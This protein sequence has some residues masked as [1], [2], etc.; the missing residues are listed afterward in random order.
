MCT[1]IDV[2]VCMELMVVTEGEGYVTVWGL[3]I[4]TNK[5][6]GCI[7][8]SRNPSRIEY[9]AFQPSLYTITSKLHSHLF[10]HL[11]HSTTQIMFT[12]TITTVAL[13]S[14]LVA[15]LPNPQAGQPVCTSST[16]YQ[17]IAE[18]EPYDLDFAI[19][20]GYRCT[21]NLADGCT[22]SSSASHTV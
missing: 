13:L 22:I 11:H 19:V 10:A 6:K 14:G 4:H 8:T 5:E 18:T 15:A 1:E 21:S 7:K 20:T 9:P 2:L 17:N 16:K 12:N 3:K